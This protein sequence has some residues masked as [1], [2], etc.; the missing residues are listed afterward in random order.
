[1][2]PILF[3]VLGVFFGQLAQP[4]SALAANVV[5]AVDTTAAP[6][7]SAMVPILLTLDPGVS[8]ATF[9]VC[10]GLEVRGPDLGK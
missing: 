6:G 2:S 4:P 5:A 7:T 3:V 10:C 1:M 8:V 9:A